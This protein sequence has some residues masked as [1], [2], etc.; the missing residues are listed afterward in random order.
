MH[1]EGEAR[2]V[3]A[4][5][6]TNISRPEIWGRQKSTGM[7]TAGQ[8][9]RH[10]NTT[11]QEVIAV[12]NVLALWVLVEPGSSSSTKRVVYVYSTTPEAPPL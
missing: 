9:L 10:R 5:Q 1:M 3:H 7:R 2:A 12:G 6:H 11:P 8:D 4:Y